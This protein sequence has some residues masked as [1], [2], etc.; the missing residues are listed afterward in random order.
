MAKFSIKE[1]LKISNGKLISGRM[2][3]GA[4]GIS[5]DSR[6]LRKGQIFIAIKGENFDGHNFVSEAFKKGACGVII[7]CNSNV[8][9]GNKIVIQ[10][11]DTVK[12]LGD[13]ASY[14][15][16]KFKIPL[17]AITGSNG[18]TTTKEMAGTILSQKFNLLATKGNLNNH[19]GVP[20]TLLDLC[21]QHKLVCLEMGTSGLGEIKYL[22]KISAPVDIG[23]ITNIQRAHLLYF[24]NLDGVL[25]AKM[26]LANSLSSQG[27]LILNIDDFHLAKVAKKIK[28]QLLTYGINNHK[29]DIYASEIK[30]Q[31]R[32]VKF[33]INIKTGNKILSQEI[34]LAILGYHN[35]YNALAAVSI[36]H[37]FNIPLKVCAMS[38]ARFKTP[39]LHM[40]I[41]KVKGARIIND[42]YNANPD[43]MKI[44]ISTL[45]NLSSNGKKI[46]VIGDMLE[47]GQYSQKVHREV[48]EAIAQ[49]DISDLFTI[50]KMAKYVAIGAVKNGFD[51]KRIFIA[52]NKK[53]IVDK[54]VNN[55]KK[56]D[57]L[58]IKGSRA[59]KMEEIIKNLQVIY[60]S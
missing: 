5:I 9:C 8:D 31:N 12:C 33:R 39:P 36:G 7:N 16:K 49:A 35:I 54:L 26:E 18:K 22:C 28:N 57:V 50:G 30:I 21:P 42:A 6:S 60:S 43:S 25:K 10:V 13:I 55:I 44:A 59:M 34:R 27:R 3:V 19:I 15:R 48:G 20:L 29:A 17:V 37:I 40:E 2:N 51:R 47:L 32:G 46:A 24:N 14:W 38:L 41:I 23:V 58:L 11:K 45:A 56:D 52:E 1:L 4:Q 53:E